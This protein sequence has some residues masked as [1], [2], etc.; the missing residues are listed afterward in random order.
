M[1]DGFDTVPISQG[2]NVDLANGTA[3][4][5][6]GNTD[7]L[8]SIENVYGSH[9][10]DTVLGSAGGNQ[11]YAGDGADIVDGGGVNDGTFDLLDGG[12]GAD[13]LTLRNNGVM[14]GGEDDDRL[15]GVHVDFDEDYINITYDTSSAEIVVNLTANTEGG[16][17][18]G[19]NTN[20]FLISDGLGGTDTVTG[21]DLITNSAFDD[22]VYVDS[23]YQN[24][25]GFNLSH[26]GL[27]AGNDT[28]TFDGV[29]IARISYDE[30]GGSVSAD[31]EAGTATD[32]VSGDS[33][34]GFDAF[35]G[36]TQF[37]GSRFDDVIY[38]NEGSDQRIR[39]NN[40]DDIITGRGGDDR[41]EGENGTG[42]VAAYSGNRSD[43]LVTD[44]GGTSVEIQ[45]L[46][47]GPNDGTDTVITT[48]FFQF[49]DGT[50]SFAE[51]FM[52]VINGT[53]GK[54][55]LNGTGADD[56]IHGLGMMIKSLQVQATTCSMEEPAKIR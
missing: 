23:T 34:I 52:N 54:D 48:E 17:A 24:G 16:L 43:Y 7:T 6:Y 44:L 40:G 3:T 50:I 31:M 37:R 29:D 18:G 36:E 27:S 14:R 9:L 25:G 55:V 45:D 32:L 13:T 39:G 28:V 5:G 56:A 8:I 51:L 33:F 21:I 19:D 49:A 26:I 10:G 41:I 12:L 47:V 46:R 22:V 20:G 35:T 1:Q 30:A 4:D 38:G 42:D 2:A 11:V 15:I 53:E